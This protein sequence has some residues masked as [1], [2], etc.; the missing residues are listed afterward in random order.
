MRPKQF[1]IFEVKTVDEELAKV[2][3]VQRFG[4]P[5]GF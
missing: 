4:K 5:D 3:V 1:Q 2:I